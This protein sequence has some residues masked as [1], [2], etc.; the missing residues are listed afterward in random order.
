MPVAV[1]RLR[2]MGLLFASPCRL[3]ADKTVVIAIL[4]LTL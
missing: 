4:G 2:V 1:L 3:L